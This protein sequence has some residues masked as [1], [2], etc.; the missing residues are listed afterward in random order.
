MAQ[1]ASQQLPENGFLKDSGG[2]AYG[3]L[4][5]TANTIYSGRE[6]LDA[7]PSRTNDAAGC[8]LYCQD[9]TGSGS[10]KLTG[11]AHFRHKDSINDPDNHD[12]SKDGCLCFVRGEDNTE[13]SSSGNVDPFPAFFSD[14]F[15]A[16]F[17]Y[18]CL[19][20][21]PSTYSV[22]SERRLAGDDSP[23]P[24]ISSVPSSQVSWHRSFLC[25]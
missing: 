21:D 6:L 5:S 7:A 19:T 4:P 16:T 9:I 11:Y 14:F 18:S 10:V 8:S 2:T 20:E 15:A 13:K 12:A 24:S 1:F 23:A 3:V 25:R 22:T 17:C